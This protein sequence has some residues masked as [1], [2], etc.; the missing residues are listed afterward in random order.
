MPSYPPPPAAFA[1]Y[2]SAGLAAALCVVASASG[3]YIV[4]SLKSHPQPVSAASAVAV[5]RAPSTP[6]AAPVA[7]AE[8]TTN[9]AQVVDVGSLSVEEH[10]A[11]A[12]PRP[13]VLPV[14]APVLPKIPPKTSEAASAKDDTESDEPPAPAPAVKKSKPVELPSAADTNP[15]TSDP[16]EDAPPAKKPAP[17]PPP[18]KDE[19]GF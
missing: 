16:T 4:Y 9:S 5:T 15:Y 17:E 6:P 10:K 1:R 18:V 3:A 7:A 8:P 12:R 11:K 19:P 2:R 14:A 13:T